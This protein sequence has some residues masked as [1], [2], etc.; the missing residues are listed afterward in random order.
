MHSRNLYEVIRV[1]KVH[2][3]NSDNML[4]MISK[5]YKQETSRRLETI[6]SDC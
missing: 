1:V 4:E 6:Y 5:N 2:I 3:R